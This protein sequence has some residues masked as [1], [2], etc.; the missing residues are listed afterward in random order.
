MAGFLIGASPKSRINFRLAMP[1]GMV[2]YTVQ[3]GSLDK[4][5]S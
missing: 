3:P 2:Y 1:S 5:K 4:E